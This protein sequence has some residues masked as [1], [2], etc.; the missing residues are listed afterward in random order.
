MPC[1][2]ARR[3]PRLG[4]PRARPTPRPSAVAARTGPSCRSTRSSRRSDVQVDLPGLRP[5]ALA[6]SP[7]GR[8]LL[9]AGKTSRA[10]RRRPGHRRHPPARAAPEDE[11]RPR[12]RRRRANI[13]AARQGRPAQLHRPDLLA[14][15]PAHLPEQ[16]QRL[17]QGRVRR[18]GGRH[19]AASRARSAC[20]RPTRPGARRR[21]PP[22]SRCRRTARGS[23]SAATCRTAA[24]AGR[25]D[26]QASCGRS[27]SASRPT[28]SCSSAARPTVSNWGGR[29]PRPGDLT[30]PAGR[31]TVVRVDP[32][33]HIASEGSVTVIDLAAGQAAGRDRDRPARQRPR[34]VART[35]ATSS[36]PTP[37]SDTPQRDRHARP[38]RWSRRSGRSRAR[39]TSSA[40]QPNALAFDPP[41]ARSTSPT[42]RRTP[43]P[44]SRSTRGPRRVEAAGADPR[45][46]VSRRARRSTRRAG[47]SY[48]ANIK[49][50]AATPEADDEER[51]G[52][53][54]FNSH[55][56]YGSLSLVPRARGR[57]RCPALSET[58][59][60]EPPPRAHRRRRSCRRGPDQPP[61]AVPERIGEP[62]LIK[63]VVYIIKE[64]RTYDQVFGDVEAR[65]RRPVAVHL[66][67]ATS[68]PTS[69]S[70]SD[71]F[72]LL[73]NTYCCRHPQR[74]RPP[75]EHHR[76]S[77]PTTWRRASPAS[78]AAI[79]TAWA[80]TRPTPWPTRPPAS[81]GTTRSRTARRIRNYGE[82]MAPA[83]RWR[84]PTKKGTPDFLAC[85]RTWKD[86]SDDVVFASEPS[87]RDHPARSRRP[88]TSAG[89]CRA[90]PV[91]GPTSFI[92]ELARVRG[93]RASSRSSSSSACPTIT[94]AAP[95]PA[96][97]R[98]RR[99]VADND[100]AF[101]R[102]VEA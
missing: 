12:P 95:A 35:A 36:A 22:A 17:D 84:D 5:Q 72:V 26:R 32:V 73:D 51:P 40:P 76:L 98:P 11:G 83:V 15:R 62:S 101:G 19:A 58:V 96:R 94:P 79:P 2:A 90:R 70:S 64:N 56:Y 8:I 87:D 60:R 28:T 16:R 25:A 24:R 39:P 4:S 61:R 1:R 42:A 92:N 57:R 3:T 53:T 44:S 80:R 86:E 54:G 29:R 13:L 6:L 31:G 21:S 18:G 30:G 88:T 67:R 77:A 41:A 63:H 102:I 59:W 65:Q 93:R 43:S 37:A 38:T 7:D 50:L 66:R 45:R 100:L 33:R 85:Y 27:T 75:V 74:R 97:P 99:C 10:R 55:H 81:S 49:G 20:P 91:S 68:R 48:V 23:T 69:T 78:R 71:E 52:A 9:T 47:R 14:R 89:R 46:L 82:F 34:R